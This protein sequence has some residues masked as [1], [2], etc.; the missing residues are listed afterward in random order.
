MVFFYGALI[1][2]DDII[3]LSA[4]RSGLQAM[5]D[6]CQKFVVMRNLKFGTNSDPIKSKTKCIVFSKKKIDLNCLKR[7]ELD[8]NELPW[9]KTVKHLGHLLQSDNSMRLDIAQKRGSFIG[10]TNGLLQEFGNVTPKVLIKILHTFAANLYGSNLWNLFGK[11]CERLFTSYNVAI[12][13]I[14]KVDRCTHRYLIEPISEAL[15]L[16]TLLAG[17]LISFH[18]S[19]IATSKFPVRFLAKLFESDLRTTHGK[20]IDEIRQQCGIDCESVE[21]IRTKVVKKQLIYK[22]PP[23]EEFWR[24]DLCKELIDIRD[25]DDIIVPG[26]TD[27]EVTQMLSIVCAA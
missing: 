6:I 10:K 13:N 24:L 17:R 3:L 11:D 26:F 7:I 22:P 25:S 8:G 1:Y 20:N 5:V 14:L 23:A 12:R 15:H 19:L 9:V 27:D 4:S 16:K 21:D 2:A 18:K